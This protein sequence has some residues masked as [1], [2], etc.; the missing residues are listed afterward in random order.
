MGHVGYLKLYF[1]EERMI[2]DIIFFT[3]SLTE[4]WLYE[5]ILVCISSEK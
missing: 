3:Q 4:C 2:I 5:N 1:S